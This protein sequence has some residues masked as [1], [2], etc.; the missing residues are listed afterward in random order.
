MSKKDSYADQYMTQEGAVIMRDKVV[1][2]SMLRLMLGITLFMIVAAIGS[3]V[4]A[5]LWV[6]LAQIPVVLMFLVLALLLPV[7]RTTVTSKELHVQY[8]LWG[9]RIAIDAIKSCTAEPYDAMKYGGWGIKRSGGVWAY[10]PTGVDDIV[11]V[12]YDHKGKEKTV[13]F[14][15]TDA[16]AVAAEINRARGMPGLRVPEDEALEESLA[17]AEA[18]AEE[19][20]ASH[21]AS[22]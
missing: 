5:G 3:G 18:L 15:A 2:R 4:A 22:N 6:A 20:A 7:L 1:S 14:G 19:E 8:G 10:V 12:V 21:E 16:Y 13:V 11:K 9:P 17:E